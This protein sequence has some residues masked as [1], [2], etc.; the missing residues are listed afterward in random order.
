M[1][2][3]LAVL[4]LGV[5]SLFGVNSALHADEAG[6]RIVFG[7]FQQSTNAYKWAQ[8]IASVSSLKT[9]V[10]KSENLESVMFRV[11]TEVLHG[12]A[13][14]EATRVA[15]ESGM[16]YWRLLEKT[17]GANSEHNPASFVTLPVVVEP[18]PIGE[19]QPSKEPQPKVEPQPSK[20]PLP[21]KEPQAA[22]SASAPRQALPSPEQTPE[23]QSEHSLDIDLALQSRWFPHSARQG[24]AR[25]HPSLA[26]QLE[27]R[28]SWNDGQ[29][30]FTFSPFA[31]YDEEDA[32]R[33]HVD[34]RELFWNR[35]ANDWE[36]NVGVQ[37]IFWGVTEFSHLVDIV[38]Q[39]DLVENPDA[40]DKLGQAM[41]NLSF[42]RDWGILDLMLLTGF[43]E[44]TFAGPGGRLDYGLEVEGSSATYAS[45]AGKNRVDGVVRWS[46]YVGPLV[47]GLYHFSGTNRDPQLQVFE[48]A[49]NEYRFRPHYTTIDQT[50]FDAQ[51]IVGD[52]IF[53]VEAI[54]RSGDGERYLASTFGFEKSF[55]GIFNSR[56]DLGLVAEFMYDE[57]GVSAPT[58]FEHDLALGTRWA[59]NDPADTQALLGVIWDTKSRETILS[60]EAS[61]RLGQNWKLILEGRAFAGA[62]ELP[63][64][65]GLDVLL[66]LQDLRNKSAPLQRDDYIQLE[67]T[68]Y[69]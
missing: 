51:A 62:T 42:V 13:L 11:A 29:D 9:R 4:L 43:R 6:Y 12:E 39:T 61:R 1:K 40:E 30:A 23:S 25:F 5:L 38:N 18:Q 48:H 68:R 67:L 55:V 2:S 34:V 37:Q 32:K 41:I 57:R 33:S 50:G 49:P 66:A 27:Y 21:S 45:G 59:L 44:R 52:W 8:H 17:P 28:S 3:L 22:S 69:F 7:S 65:S 35:V 15:K 26:L 58:L 64:G 20:E 36:L 47:F 19:P 24:Q 54:R 53:K 31:R 60:L 46:H 16:P 63:A 56:A 10:Q 14:A